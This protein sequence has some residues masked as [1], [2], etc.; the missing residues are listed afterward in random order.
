M[1][2]PQ[3]KAANILCEAYHKT[4]P[5]GLFVTS[6]E[7]YGRIMGKRFLL[8]VLYISVKSCIN[9]FNTRKANLSTEWCDGFS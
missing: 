8:T 7:F 6:G 4:T 2:Q 5:Q 3:D 9:S 1:K